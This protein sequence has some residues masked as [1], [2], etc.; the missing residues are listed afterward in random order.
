MLSAGVS[1]PGWLKLMQEWTWGSLGMPHTVHPGREAGP[2][3]CQLGGSRVL[4]T[5]DALASQLRPGCS[6]VLCTCVSHI[7]TKARAMVS[8]SEG[9][10]AVYHP[11]A[12]MIRCLWLVW[13]RGLGFTEATGQLGYPD[14][15][16]WS[17]LSGWNRVGSTDLVSQPLPPWDSSNSLAEF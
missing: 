5:R 10:P 8:T 16:H 17:L 2:K 7:G 15:V 14:Y 1:L 11:V 12:T 6:I 3:T 4:C 13:A 9:C